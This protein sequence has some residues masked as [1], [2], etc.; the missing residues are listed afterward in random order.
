MAFRKG[1]RPVKR[2][3]LTKR[4]GRKKTY[5]RRKFSGNVI[6]GF[7]DYFKGPRKSFNKSR[8]KVKLNFGGG[9]GRSLVAKESWLDWLTNHIWT[10]AKVL[11]P[12][13]V[14]AIAFA[15]GGEIAAFLGASDGT[16][17]SFKHIGNWLTN[18]KSYQIRLLPDIIQTA[19]FGIQDKLSEEASKTIEMEGGSQNVLFND[20][21]TSVPGPSERTI[22]MNIDT[23]GSYSDAGLKNALYES[24]YEDKWGRPFMPTTHSKEG[25]PIWGSSAGPMDSYDTRQNR[26]TRAPLF[27]NR[28]ESRRD[29]KV[30][31]P[32]GHKGFSYYDPAETKS[33]DMRNPGSTFN[34]IQLPKKWGKQ[35]AYINQY[36]KQYTS[37]P[38]MRSTGVGNKIGPMSKAYTGEANKWGWATPSAQKLMRTHTKNVGMNSAAY[39]NSDD[40]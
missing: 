7:G 5:S 32:A 30:Y 16:W 9:G 8:A 18:L 37:L 4:Y 14:G 12:I 36:A 2:R 38:G 28:R 35:Q 31:K 11:G 19:L 10:A 21:T 40:Y 25:N 34:D 23:S 1:R 24:A 6:H 3:R 39:K 20:T 26:R 27:H 29:T 22:P 33:F 13:A 15:Y 17:E